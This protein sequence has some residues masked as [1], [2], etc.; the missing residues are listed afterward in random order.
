MR[1]LSTFC[2]GAWLASV[3]LADDVG[4]GAWSQQA[5]HY[6]A[7]LSSV[8]YGS[9]E[10]YNE[11]GKLSPAGMN[12]ETFDS[13][14]GFAYVEYGVRDRLTL[15]GKL[16]V[17]ELVAEDALVKQTTIGIGDAEV[18]AKYQLTDQV[19][20]VSPMV[21]IKVPTGYDKGFDP[22][23]G[24]GYRDL[25]F[26][27][28]VARSLYPWPLYVGGEL[29][30]RFRGG[31]YSNQV[32]Y[33]AELGVTPHPRLFAKVYVDGANTLS[34]QREST[35]EVGVFQVSEGDFRKMGANVAVNVEGPVWIDVLWERIVDGQNVGAGGSWGFGVAY[36]Y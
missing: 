33:F 4:A 31:P 22:A 18:G 12:D 26:R 29:G 27:T 36:S 25:E 28:L 8:F 14:Q 17:G 16:A 19:V 35:G 23:M 13:G 6:Y 3:G 1:H 11:M 9:D 21:S 15:V 2:L 5:G 32:P 30:Y 10:I 7:K 20:V 24:T 34:G